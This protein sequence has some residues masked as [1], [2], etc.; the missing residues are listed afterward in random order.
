MLDFFEDLTYNA[1][2]GFCNFLWN[3]G[4]GLENFA[5][6]I[7]VDEEMLETIPRKLVE[8]KRKTKI[9]AEGIFP[10]C[11]VTNVE[12][13]VEQIKVHRV[14]D[15]FDESAIGLAKDRIID[16]C[17][18]IM[19]NAGSDVEKH[20]ARELV[21][22]LWK[23]AVIIIDADLLLDKQIAGCFYTKEG[24]PYIGLDIAVLQKSDDAILVNT[25]VHEAYHAWRYF[26]SATEYSIIDERRAWNTALGFSNKYR[27]MYGI[28]IEREQEYTEGELLRHSDYFS[29]INVKVRYGPGEHIIEKIG[30]GIAN[31]IE[32][33]TDVVNEWNLKIMDRTLREYED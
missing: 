25:L 12:V 32:D 11:S 1:V 15:G 27:N 31:L 23:G 26:T 19:G 17:K 5:D 28:P 22:M 33:A 16:A 18:F 29:N 14:L 13:T 2:E 8:K 6:T 4:E 21:K 10:R 9:P 24:L 7:K 3:I 20:T 30:Y